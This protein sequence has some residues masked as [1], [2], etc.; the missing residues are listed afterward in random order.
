MYSISDLAQLGGV[1]PRMLRHYHALGIFVPARIDPSGYRRYGPEQLA[2]LLRVIALKELGF[3]LAD[4]K[5]IT[6]GAVSPAEL[7]GMLL[8]R[9]AEAR[10]ERDQ[11]DSRLS[12]IESHIQRL[13]FHVSVRHDRSVEVTTRSIPPAHIAVVS[14]VSP[15]FEPDDIGP[16]IQPLFPRLLDALQAH[17][18]GADGAPIAY[19]K[20]TDDGAVGVHVGIPVPAHV[21][22]IPGVEVIDLPGI[23]LAA[24]ALHHGDMATV[25]LNTTPAVF[26]WLSAHGFQTTDYSRE[27]YLEWPEDITKARTEMIFPIEADTR[28]VEEAFSSRDDSLSDV[29]RSD[30]PTGDAPSGRASKVMSVSMP[31]DDQDAAIRFYTEVLGFE[32]RADIQAWP[33]ARWVE[34]ALPRSDVSIAL[35]PRDGEIPVA[36]RLQTDHAETAFA[37]ISDAGVKRHND[38]VIRI[39]GGPPMFHFEDPDGNGLVFLEF[40]A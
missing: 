25:D 26:E 7:R 33:G 35:L 19:Y 11:A 8:L 5:R 29:S 27:V 30:L 28:Q 2:E 24:V 18:V 14:S 37:A 22:S 38:S 13:E 40:T 39:D 20:D 23:E 12:R 4:V 31:V 3:A 34:V 15:T 16:V 6:A 21:V 17:G 9:R 32:L 36:V 1:T 10:S